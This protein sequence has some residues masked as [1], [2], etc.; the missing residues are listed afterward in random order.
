MALLS[1][2]RGNQDGPVILAGI[3]GWK[4]EGFSGQCIDCHVPTSAMPTGNSVEAL[5]WAFEEGTEF[6][7]TV[8]EAFSDD[9]AE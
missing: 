5:R 7:S 6:T 1:A 8:G 9:H 3:L 4:V 2:Y